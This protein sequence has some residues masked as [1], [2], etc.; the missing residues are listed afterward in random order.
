MIGVA[1]TLSEKDM[2]MRWEGGVHSCI[3]H[4]QD[5]MRRGR[6]ETVW[7]GWSTDGKME[8]TRD[9][10]RFFSKHTQMAFH[11]DWSLISSLPRMLGG[12]WRVGDTVLDGGHDGMRLHH[13]QESPRPRVT[14]AAVVQA[15]L[16]DGGNIKDGVS[17]KQKN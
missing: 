11:T 17:V 4:Q 12:Q 2:N 10:D 1:L 14:D 16:S 9:D 6:G 8:L 3:D 7:G 5:E 13:R 15:G